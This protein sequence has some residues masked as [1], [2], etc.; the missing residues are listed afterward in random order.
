MIQAEVL[1]RLRTEAYDSEEEAQVLRDALVITITGI[2]TVRMRKLS[3]WS[4]WQTE[5]LSNSIT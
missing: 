1:R 5:N 4:S 2:H 3:N